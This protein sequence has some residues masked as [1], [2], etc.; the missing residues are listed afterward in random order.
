MDIPY[1]APKF[2]LVGRYMSR[3]VSLHDGD[4]LTCVIGLFGTCWR[5]SVRIDG[6][7]T[8]EMTS[9]TPSAYKARHRLFQMVTGDTKT[10]TLTFKKADFDRYFKQNYTTLTFDAI[11]FD[12][13]GRVL[14][15]I[16]WISTTLIAEGLAYEYHG[17]T[18]STLAADDPST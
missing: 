11:G 18:K 13:Y 15:S 12:K 2:E 7:D 5:F 9:K 16:P 1:D 17:G 6:I 10:D 4:T 3:V 8:P 14:A